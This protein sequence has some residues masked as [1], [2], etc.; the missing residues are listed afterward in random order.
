MHFLE[1]CGSRFESFQLF[2]AL[3]PGTDFFI[4]INSQ[5]VCRVINYLLFC[6]KDYIH[7]A[8]LIHSPQ[9]KKNCLKLDVFDQ[10]LVKLAIL[11]GV[12]LTTILNLLSTKS[13]SDVFFVYN[14]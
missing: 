5:I 9:R 3:S 13:D 4:D 14:C 2:G 11:H 1:K 7:N 10:V 12:S 6:D 8:Y